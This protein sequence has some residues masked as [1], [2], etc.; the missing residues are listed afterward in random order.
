MPT[1]LFGGTVRPPIF[2]L[3]LLT[4]P[5][6]RYAWPGDDLTADFTVN[7]RDSR[8]EVRCDLTR[9]D[10]AE[11]LSMLSMHA[12]DLARAAVDSFCFLA[13]LA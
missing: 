1:V 12:Y 11:H 9:F 13:E 7:V 2:K 6:I 4:L 8:L 3:H 5:M 10:K